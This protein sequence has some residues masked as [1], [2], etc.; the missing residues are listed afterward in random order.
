MGRKGVPHRKWSKEEKMKLIQLHLDEHKSLSQIEKEYSVSK[1]FFGSQVGVVHLQ[2]LRGDF[3]QGNTTKI[4]VDMIR[5][6]IF[7][8]VNCCLFTIGLYD[9]VEPIG[10]PILNRELGRSNQSLT[11]LFVFVLAK[12]FAGFGDR[13]KRVGLFDWLAIGGETEV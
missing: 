8:A 11:I 7:I 4:R 3:L 1:L 2:F 5:D 13:L 12:G 9:I 6:H 10:Q